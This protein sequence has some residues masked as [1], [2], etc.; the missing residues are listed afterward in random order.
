[1]RRLLLLKLLLS[2]MSQCLSRT[3]SRTMETHCIGTHEQRLK[4]SGCGLNRANHDTMCAIARMRSSRKASVLAFGGSVTWGIPLKLPSQTYLNRFAESLQRLGWVEHVHVRNRAIRASTCETALLCFDELVSLDEDSMSPIVGDNAN[5]TWTSWRSAPK[6]PLVPSEPPDVVILE[7]SINGPGGM[8]EMLLSTL[9]ARYPDAI[10]LYVQHFELAAELNSSLH[11]SKSWLATSSE[12]CVLSGGSQPANRSLEEVLKAHRAHVFSMR[13]VARSMEAPDAARILFAPDK[14][15]LPT[16]GHQWVA[17]GLLAILEHVAESD[18]HVQQ[19]RKCD[20]S[21][22]AALN[23]KNVSTCHMWFQTGRVSGRVRVLRDTGWVM[24][25]LST[26][27]GK[28]AFIL[29]GANWSDTRL[30]SVPLGLGFHAERG[31]HV[32]LVHMQHV[33]YYGDATAKLDEHHPMVI[34]GHPEVSGPQHPT[35]HMLKVTHVGTVT[36]TGQHQIWVRA[37]YG[38]ESRSTHQFAVTGLV[39]GEVKAHTAHQP[40]R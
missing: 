38:I 25:P 24:Q 33:E 11:W 39:V 34:S 14:T 7:F 32:G 30:H 40:L 3:I 31:S 10:I 12:R 1:M 9:R 23:P 35:H 27:G 2:S 22:S 18:V 26:T 20:P 5:P 29:E 19:Q 28:Y 36:H 16:C 6:S 13:D 4:Q 17:A 37:H 8:L 15:H 21:R